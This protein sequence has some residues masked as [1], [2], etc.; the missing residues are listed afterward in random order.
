[1]PNCIVTDIVSYLDDGGVLCIPAL[2]DE[3]YLWKFGDSYF[4]VFVND[5][6]V[7]KA[8]DVNKFHGFVRN[9]LVQGAEFQIVTDCTADELNSC[10]F[11]RFLN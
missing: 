1:L 4:V 2:D 11:A 5:Q 6:T 8:D 9:L 10:I 7:Y 3:A